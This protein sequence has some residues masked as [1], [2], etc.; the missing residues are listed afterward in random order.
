MEKVLRNIFDGRDL[1]NRKIN[2]SVVATQ[3]PPSYGKRSM[4]PDYI[5]SHSEKIEVKEPDLNDLC[6]LLTK[7]MA[8]VILLKTCFDDQFSDILARL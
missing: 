8:C 2:V 1:A 7:R 3:N 4:L 6:I 5:L